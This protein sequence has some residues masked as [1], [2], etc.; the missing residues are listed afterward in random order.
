M[1]EGSL[2][3]SIGC[4]PCLVHPQ[5]NNGTLQSALLKAVTSSYNRRVHAA[6]REG[7]LEHLALVTE[8]RYRV[9]HDL[10]CKATTFNTKSHS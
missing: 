3:N 2:L 7:A 10:L 8:L 1:A 9:P 5:Q 6:L 4:K